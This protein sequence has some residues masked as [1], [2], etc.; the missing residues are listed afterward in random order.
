MSIQQNNIPNLIIGNSCRVAQMAMERYCPHIK[1]N[2]VEPND[3][4]GGGQGKK[5]M[6]V[7]LAKTLSVYIMRNSFGFSFGK[8]MRILHIPYKETAIRLS[9]GFA[10]QI[11]QQDPIA[12]FAYEQMNS[13]IY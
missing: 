12:V 8:I 9:S 3:I 4:I 7:T 11:A 2:A 10:S 1:D 5:S 13:L 6:T